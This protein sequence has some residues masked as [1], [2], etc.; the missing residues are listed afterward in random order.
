M[1]LLLILG[2]IFA[3]GAVIFALQNNVTVMVT[4]A[5]WSFEST[6]AVVLLLTLGIG[7][8]IAALVTTPRALRV[9]WN[10]ARLR[11]Q[12]AMLEERNAQLEKRLNEMIAAAPVPAAETKP[13]VGLK[14]LLTGGRSVGDKP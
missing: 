13:Y 3:V 5:F 4:L 1:Q 7:V 6:L 2:I 12:V 11:R 10:A 8:L 9:Q 14:T